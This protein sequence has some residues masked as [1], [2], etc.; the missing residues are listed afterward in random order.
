MARRNPNCGEPTSFAA[1]GVTVMQKHENHAMGCCVRAISVARSNWS[2]HARLH[3]GSRC[4]SSIYLALPTTRAAIH[5]RRS[6]VNFHSDPTFDKARDIL[7]GVLL[8]FSR[9]LHD[10]DRSIWTQPEDSIRPCCSPVLASQRKDT[11]RL[12]EKC[13]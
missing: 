3:F 4:F 5:L 6:R 9:P 7:V 10:I 11:C 2:S 1:F 8:T 12:S 13:A